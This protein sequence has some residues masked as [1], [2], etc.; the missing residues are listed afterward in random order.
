MTRF[1]RRVVGLA[2]ALVA[3]PFA[4]TPLLIVVDPPISALM[5]WRLADG[6]GIDQR[7]VALGDIAPALA[8]TV[9]M[10]EDARFCSH[11]G[12]DW[13]AVQEVLGEV[14]EGDAPR[15]AS[16]IT[17]Q[18]AKNLFLWP[19]RSYVRKGFEVPLAYWMD[20]L[21]SKR[22]IMEIYLNVV[23]WAPGIYGAEAAAR[24]HFGKSANSLSAREAGLLA[25]VLPNPIGRDAGK[26]GPGT[27]RLGARA[28]TLGRRAGGYDDC[29]RGKFGH[30]H[31]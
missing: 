1:L 5:L 3:L 9:L 12:V 30:E 15:G 8:D 2:L 20:F 24:H 4:M 16:T 23:E 31:R 14:A 26:P 11:H 29:L 10:T 13:D 19:Q 18:T 21:L 7:W 28:A 22:R 27:A 17:M 6:R 25:A